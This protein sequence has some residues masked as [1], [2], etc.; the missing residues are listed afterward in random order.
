MAPKVFVT[1]GTGYIGGDFLHV[2]TSKHPDW[3]LTC[4]VRNSDKGAKIAAVYPK[5]RLVYGDLDAIELI[6][7]E[8]SSADIVYHFANCDHE[9]SANAITRGLN[10]RTSSSPAFW[11]HTS[12]TGILTWETLDQKAFG[13]ELARKFNDW[14]GIQELLS[15]PDRALHRPVDKIVIAAA[16]DKIKTAIVCP[17]TIY[18]PGRGPDNQ[19]SMQAYK[20]AA[21]MM[22]S[23]QGFVIGKGENVWHQVHVQDLTD[24]YVLLGEAAANGGAPATWN[25]QGY[26]LAENGEFVWGDILKAI[27]ADAH[28]KGFLPDSTT[29]GY[30]PEDVASVM[31]RGEYAVGSNSR[32]ESIRGKRLLGWKPYRPLLRDLVPEI[33]DIEARALG[34]S[35]G[36]AETVQG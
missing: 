5:I 31:P 27:V 3:E 33:V 23:K 15:H 13:D 14:D 26:Y 28:G 24:L 21:A 25:Y 20:A 18:G 34:L 32:G 7:E 19:K 30:S 10:R 36:H 2:I 16:S 8:S 4:L 22:K 17:P 12:G 35:K 9:A 29:K 11:I 6:E 1:G